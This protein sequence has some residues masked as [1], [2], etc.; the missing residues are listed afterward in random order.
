MDF[1]G[2]EEIELSLGLAIGGE[3]CRKKARTEDRTSDTAAVEE[4]KRKKEMQALR[5]SE[6]RRKREEKK[7]MRVVRNNSISIQQPEDGGIASAYDGD[8]RLEKTEVAKS[9]AGED[10]ELASSA[11]SFPIYAYPSYQYVPFPNG[12]AIPCIAPVFRADS[13]SINKNVANQTLSFLPLNSGNKS[14]VVNGV[15]ALNEEAIVKAVSNGS[16]GCCSSA[17]SE[18]RSISSQ[19]E[20]HLFQLHK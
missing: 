20:F 19:G 8:E 15:N 3:G 11:Y 14:H 1:E 13:E 17:V 16:V 7:R 9:D 6:A 2:E 12:F 18:N 10:T 5:R 4:V